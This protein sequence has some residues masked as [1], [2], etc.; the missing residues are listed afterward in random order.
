MDLALQSLERQT[1]K[2]FEVIAVDDCS[3][4]STNEILRTWKNQLPIKIVQG[5][6]TGIGAALQS[7]FAQCQGEFIARF[8]ADDICLPNRL[9]HQVEMLV[10]NHHLGLVGSSVDC[11]DINGA[12]LFTRKFPQSNSAIKKL[13]F[14]RNP[15]CHGSIMARKD[16]LQIVGGWNPC[17]KVVEDYELW[18]RFLKHFQC[19]NEETVLLKYRV[20]PDSDS[21]SKRNQYDRRALTTRFVAL[22]KGQVSLI[23]ASFL[24]FIFVWAYLPHKM[25][26]HIGA[27]FSTK[28]R[29]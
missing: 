10:K 11:I 18:F 17:R 3:T 20:H 16:C 8:D 6:G 13:L 21:I 23:Y 14:F 4:D 7:G 19:E 2:A 28:I 15:F 22:Q 26:R 25:L 5:L 27:R 9:Q 24:P 29:G 12:H 1:Y